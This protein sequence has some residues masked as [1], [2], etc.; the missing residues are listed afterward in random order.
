MYELRDYQHELLADANA[1]LAR[2]NA[3]M[4]TMATGAGK[5][6]LAASFAKAHAKTLFICHTRA[7]IDQAPAEFAKWGITA[8][9]VGGKHGAEAWDY[10]GVIASTPAF[11]FNRLPDMAALLDSGFSALIVDEAHHAADGGS[12]TTALVELFKAWDMPVFGMTATPTRLSNTQGFDK[13]WDQLVHGPQWSDLRGTYLADVV[14][15]CRDEIEGVGDNGRGEFRTS[16]THNHNSDNPIYTVGAFDEIDRIGRNEDGTLK[17]TIM[18][19]VSQ[20]HAANLAAVASA[21]GIPCGVMISDIDTLD[22]VDMPATGAP[23]LTDRDEVRAGFEDGSIRLIINVNMITEGFDMPG[24]A[25]VVCL[26]PTQSLSLWK[27][28]CGRASRLAPGKEHALIIDLTDNNKRLGDALADHEWSLAAGDVA[29][30]GGRPWL[31]ACDTNAHTS[32]D[33]MI[34]TGCHTC[35]T[36]RGPQGQTCNLCGRFRLWSRFWGTEEQ[37][38]EDCSPE[39]E[40][41]QQ[42]IRWNEIQLQKTQ[43]MQLK[44]AV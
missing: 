43:P 5:T 25:T 21:R 23:V 6:A 41:M 15:V 34:H 10:L 26:R 8:R 3:V 1:A 20:L 11:A 14:M 17:R 24:V 28:M 30:T 27:Q 16:A 12:R 36:C 29:T 19:A 18:Y 39:W 35:P 40:R 44:L 22:D 31:R 42:T 33:S 7:V 4:V 38:C 2:S 32:C 9:A 37:I 13:T